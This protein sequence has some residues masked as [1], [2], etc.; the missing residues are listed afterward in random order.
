M[1]S[2]SSTMVDKG[3]QRET[4][5]L[6]QP[7][8]QSLPKPSTPAQ[9]RCPT[10]NAHVTRQAPSPAE[11]AESGDVQRSPPSY[12]RAGPLMDNLLH[13]APPPVSKSTSLIHCANTAPTPAMDL[14]RKDTGRDGKGPVDTEGRIE[15]S[16][17]ITKPLPPLPSSS[18]PSPTSAAS[19]TPSDWDI[20]FE[21]T[22]IIQDTNSCPALNIVIFIVGSRGER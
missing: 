14:L 9:S 5:D 18:R 21:S 1:S 22:K 3:K 15:L 11:R 20:D 19:R 8:R 4:D 2:S 12:L 6:R 17:N 7:P 10:T 16:L 13:S